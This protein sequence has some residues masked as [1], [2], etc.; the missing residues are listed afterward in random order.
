MEELDDLILNMV[1]RKGKIE[2]EVILKILFMSKLEKLKLIKYVNTLYLKYD[3]N[4]SLDRLRREILR[5]I[6]EENKK[7]M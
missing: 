5:I 1:N 7:C 4:L 3:I 2:K 6:K